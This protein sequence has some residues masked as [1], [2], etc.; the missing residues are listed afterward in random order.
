MVNCKPEF[1]VATKINVSVLFFLRRLLVY[2]FAIE[3]IQ[4]ISSTLLTLQKLSIYKTQDK[5]RGG[6]HHGVF[7]NPHDVEI[8]GVGSFRGCPFSCLFG[9]RFQ[10]HAGPAAVTPLSPRSF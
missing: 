6:K 9:R 5:P 3:C 4:A 2:F 7:A 10:L 1:E 8:C